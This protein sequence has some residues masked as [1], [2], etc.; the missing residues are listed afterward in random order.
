MPRRPND[1]Y[2]TE[3]SA[4]G[5]LLERVALEG[6]TVIEPCHGAGDITLQ[7]IRRADCRV[8]T[9]DLDPGFIANYRLDAR[10]PSAWRKFID[11]NDYPIGPTWAVTNP[12]FIYAA[13]IARRALEHVPNVALLLRL[14]FLEPCEDR[15]MLLAERPPR[16]LIVL[17]RISFTNDGSTDSVTCAWFVWSDQVEPGIE[18]VPTLGPP[19]PMLE[20]LT[21]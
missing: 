6:A 8:I 12:P 5:A 13:D 18:V 21:E 1:F 9:N 14:T 11:E 15:V 17:P 2:P 4:T 7:L 19:H 20:G 10:L 16:R 3:A